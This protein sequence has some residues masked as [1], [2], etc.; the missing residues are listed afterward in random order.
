[1]PPSALPDPASAEITP[2]ATATWLAR[3]PAAFQ[4]IDCREPDEWALCRLPHA[5]L[6]PLSQFAEAAPSLITSDRP[7]VVYCHHGLRSLRATHWL[8]Q[9]G[10]SAWSLAGGI[11]AWSTEIDESIPRY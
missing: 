4:L 7:V 1:M 5:T 8:R 2:A 3:D 6:V 9:K 10:Y 11:D